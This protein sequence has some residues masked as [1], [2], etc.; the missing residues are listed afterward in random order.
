MRRTSLTWESMHGRQ[1]LHFMDIVRATAAET[2]TP[3]V[4]H[5]KRWEPLRLTEPALYQALMTDALHVN[6]LGNMVMGLDLIRVFEAELDETRRDFCADGLRYQRILDEL[7]QEGKV[8]GMIENT[9]TPEKLGFLAPRLARIDSLMQDYVD[10]SKLAGIIALVA[11]HG[12]VA[13]CKR[14]GWMDVEAAKPMSIGRY[15]PYFFDDQTHHQR[16]DDDAL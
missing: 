6:P 15:L 10:Q 3:L 9:V 12:Q 5:H 2:H 8:E 13:Y 14:F 16:G 1:F 4:D 11:R 7:S